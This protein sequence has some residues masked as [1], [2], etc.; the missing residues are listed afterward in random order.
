MSVEAW[1]HRHPVAFW[2]SFWLFLAFALPLLA[3]EAVGIVYLLQH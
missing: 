1:T 3:L 2:V